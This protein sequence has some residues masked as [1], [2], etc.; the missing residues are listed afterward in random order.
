MLSLQQYQQYMV[1]T[2]CM[3]RDKDGEKEN[4]EN[5][6]VW[7]HVSVAEPFPEQG[8]GTRRWEPEETPLLAPR[9]PSGSGAR[10]S[11]ETFKLSSPISCSSW[12]WALLLLGI[13]S[14]CGSRHGTS[15]PPKPIGLP[16]FHLASISQQGCRTSLPP[17]PYAI[18]PGRPVLK[19]RM[20]GG[21]P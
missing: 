7:Q 6:P 2:G 13:L 12:Q 3:D 4:R 15:A 1:R 20:T 18:W 17:P 16:L 8:R 5:I 14:L 11:P 19:L 9:K 10:F 21:R